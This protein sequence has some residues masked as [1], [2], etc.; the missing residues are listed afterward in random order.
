MGY[1][2]SV[3]MGIGKPSPHC[4]RNH[5]LVSNRRLKWPPGCGD[6]VGAPMFQSIIFAIILY[7]TPSLLLVALLTCR[8]GFSTRDQQQDYLFD[9]ELRPSRER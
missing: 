9:E 8:E 7:L 5:L 1:A 4:Q 2:G 3:F 6:T